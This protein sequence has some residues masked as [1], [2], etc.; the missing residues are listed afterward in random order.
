MRRAERV[1]RVEKIEKVERVER[2][3]RVKRVGEWRRG[4]VYVVG[5]EQQ[6]ES[7]R[8]GK[9]SVLPTP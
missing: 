7:Q 1:E 8:E 2:V 5:Q 3:E 9:V 4:G 6:I